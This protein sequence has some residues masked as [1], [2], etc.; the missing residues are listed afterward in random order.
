M[1]RCKRKAP[2]KWQARN[3]NDV[4]SHSKECEMRSQTLLVGAEKSN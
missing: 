2:G 4:R 1:T 3:D